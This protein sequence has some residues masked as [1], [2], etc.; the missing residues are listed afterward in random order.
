MFRFF[1]SI[2]NSPKRV[3]R[4]PILAEHESQTLKSASG[5]SFRVPVGECVWHRGGSRCTS[6]S[7]SRIRP[8]R[9]KSAHSAPPPRKA[10][11]SKSR[12]QSIED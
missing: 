10:K 5:S 7:R 2:C 11:K 12:Q 6:Q 4:S 9:V 1:C 8:V 3:R